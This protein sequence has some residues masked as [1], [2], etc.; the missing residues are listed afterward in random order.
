MNLFQKRTVNIN[1]C[2]PMNPPKFELCT[3]MSLLS[4]LNEGGILHNLKARYVANIIYTYSGLFCV[5]VN[6]YKRFPIYTGILKWCIDVGK[7]LWFFF[8]IRMINP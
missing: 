6:P 2:Q 5:A 7:F 8:I 4:Y 1:E 3:D